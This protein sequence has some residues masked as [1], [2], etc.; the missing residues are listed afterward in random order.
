MKYIVNAYKYRLQT[1]FTISQRVILSKQKCKKIVHT[2]YSRNNIGQKCEGN[3]GLWV[4]IEIIKET[5]PEM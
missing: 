4:L 2:T 5:Y 1:Y 3:C